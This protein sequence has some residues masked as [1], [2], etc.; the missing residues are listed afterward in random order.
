ME[1]I[2]KSTKRENILAEFPSGEIIEAPLGTT[3]EELARFYTGENFKALAVLTEGTLKELTYVPDRDLKMEILDITSSEGIRIYRRSLAFMF[4]TAV[5]EL[6]PEAEVFIDYTVPFGGYFCKLSARDNFTREE[7]KKIEDHMRQ[8][9]EDDNPIHRVPVPIEKAKEIFKSRNELDKLCLVDKRGKDTFMMYQLRNRKDAFYGY[10]LPSTGY[11]SC[12][13]LVPW[14]DGF[15]LQ[16]PRRSQSSCLLETYESPMLTSVFQEYGNWLKVLGVENVSCINK[17]IEENNIKETILVSEALQEQRIARISGEI[18]EKR[19]NV[20]LVLIAG[21]SS[22]GKTTFSKRLAVQLL[23]HGVKPFTLEMDRYFVE[24]DK[25]PLDENGE[26]NF[27]TIDALDLELLNDNLNALMNGEKVTL[28]KFD[29]ITGTRKKGHKA[30]LDENHIIIAEGIHG[31]NPKLVSHVREESIFRIYISALTQLNIDR[32][33][34]VS[35]T[36]SRL[37]RRIVRDASQR[38]A[39]ADHTLSMWEKV[40]AGEKTYIFPFQENAD[41]MFNSAL[42][43]EMAVLKPL[44]APLLHRVKHVSP[45]SAT[46]KRL[47]ALLNLIESI[48]SDMVPENSIIREFIGGSILRDYLP[49]KIMGS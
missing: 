37:I 26:F 30:H 8:I 11:L 15:V 32:H 14:E 28:P 35:T 2:K 40:R 49:G 27:E 25:T 44:A 34:R 13:A 43:Y 22:S 36:D 46:A 18:F 23:A 17:L 29:F 1:K 9:V 7:L 42:A 20:K 39:S 19:D 21:P 4:V 24:R 31:L 12:F 16:Y 33:N 6:F 48:P 10:M 3:A 47:L 38:G 41:V 5:E 45:N